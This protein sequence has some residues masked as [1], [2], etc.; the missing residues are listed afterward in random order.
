MMSSEGIFNGIYL[1]SVVLLG[2][3][4]SDAAMEFKN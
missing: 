2:G 1:E 3:G 4:I